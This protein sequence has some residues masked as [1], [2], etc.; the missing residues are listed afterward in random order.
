[1]RS[2]RCLRVDF[3]PENR[4]DDAGEDWGQFTKTKFIRA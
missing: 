2:E 3:L 4:Y 1:M